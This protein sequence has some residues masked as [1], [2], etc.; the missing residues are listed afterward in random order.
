LG[1]NNRYG[2][3]NTPTNKANERLIAAADPN[4]RER[5]TIMA[6]TIHPDPWRTKGDYDEDRLRMKHVTMASVVS[7]IAA[8]IS[9]VAALIAVLYAVF[10]N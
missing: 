5:I 9:S 10:K 8:A 2:N 3:R 6:E 7:S 1:S 4:V